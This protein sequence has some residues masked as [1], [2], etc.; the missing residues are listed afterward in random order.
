L[1]LVESYQPI[2]SGQVAALASAQAYFIGI[3]L[4]C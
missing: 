4:E 1:K 3:Q 2:K